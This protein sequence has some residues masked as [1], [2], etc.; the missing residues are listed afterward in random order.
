MEK[1][2]SIR[3]FSAAELEA[4][5]ARGECGS[6]LGR[7]RAKSAEELERDIADDPDF[8]NEAEDWYKAAEAVMPRPKKLLSLRL[9]DD[10]ID[11]FKQQGPGYQ[12]RINAVLRA[13]VQRAEKK[14]A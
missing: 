6:D 8:R 5:R 9:D 1:G 7:V 11:W 10:V 4:R 14:R 3:K 2:R 13:F 12:T